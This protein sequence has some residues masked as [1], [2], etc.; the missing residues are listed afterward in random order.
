[1]TSAMTTL[2]KDPKDFVQ[3]TRGYLMDLRKLAK[4]SPAAHQ[5]LWLLTERMNKT[6]AVVMTHKVMGHILGYSPATI[7]RAVNLLSEE[8]WI[9]VVKI[10]TSHGYIVNS[11]VIWRAQGGKR[12]TSF[13]AEVVTN[14]EEQSHPIEDW[15][16]VELRHV[17]ILQAGEVPIDDGA[18]LPPPDQ[19]DLLPPDPIEFPRL[20]EESEDSIRRLELEKRGQRRIPE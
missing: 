1:M 4:R 10:G 20:T 6:N 5:I 11:K 13:F 2:R 19:R 17:P 15:D 18:D 7:Y 12:Y 3:L 14:E 16:N 8:K 9:Q